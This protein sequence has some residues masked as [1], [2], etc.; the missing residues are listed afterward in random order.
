MQEP[1]QD[2]IRSEHPTIVMLDDAGFNE[3]G[4]HAYANAIS[5]RPK[6]LLAISPAKPGWFFELIAPAFPREL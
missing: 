6:K 5:T 4:A 3:I 1:G 2:Q